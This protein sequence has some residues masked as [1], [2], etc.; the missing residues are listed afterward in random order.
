MTRLEA[1]EK[2][3]KLK[4]L[5]K[6]AGSPA[7]A[8]NARGAAHKIVAKYQLT[9]RELASGA[10]AN[11]LDDLLGALDSFV[12]GQ[13]EKV[14]AA[15]LDVIERVKRDT[16]PEEKAD[17]LEKLVGA[18]RVV[19]MFFGHRDDVSRIRDIIEQTLQQHEITI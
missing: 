7:E 19:A 10:K 8:E 15:V 16:K 4:R 17:A 14:P 3:A 5:A 6:R 9:P 11:A 1:M 18:T 13:R 2:V 12:K